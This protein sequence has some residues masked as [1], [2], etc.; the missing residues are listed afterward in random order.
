[1]NNSVHNKTKRSCNEMK[2]KVAYS[3]PYITHYVYRH[4]KVDGI[5]YQERTKV[6]TKETYESIMYQTN[7]YN[8]NIL[9]YLVCNKIS[10][11]LL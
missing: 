3:S 7:R 6:F 9:K 8:V 1:M 5:I 4:R 2:V 10:T 11:I